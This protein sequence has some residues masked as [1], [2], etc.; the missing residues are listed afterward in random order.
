MPTPLCILLVDDSPFFLNLE[1]QFLRNTPA[2]LLEAKT[3][4][5]ALRLA[6]SHRPSLVFMN[7]DMPEV[8]GITCCRQFRADPD[9]QTIPVILIGNRMHA[10]QQAQ[11]V[12]AG[13][14]GFLSKPLDRR[15]FLELGHHLLVSIDR[16]EPRRNCEIPVS[17]E[18][19]GA[20]RHGLCVDISSGGMFLKIDPAA[21]K[22]EVL[23]LRL[24]LPDSER[25][26]VVLTGRVA[27]VNMHNDLIKPDYPVGYGLEFI[28]ISE[29]AGIALR[30]CFGV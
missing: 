21:S 5:E 6:R 20:D 30:R 1:R 24:R 7:I 3:V 26:I 13:C 18:W 27:W 15:Q 9:L 4:D 22:G 25:T 12:A 29:A 8:D 10:E 28:D 16:R 17:F 23:S 19:R 11:A 14:S 2:S